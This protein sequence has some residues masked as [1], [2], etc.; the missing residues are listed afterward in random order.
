[1]AVTVCRALAID[2]WFWA[3]VD[4]LLIFCCLSG[5]LLTST[6]VHKD[7]FLYFLSIHNLATRFRSRLVRWVKSPIFLDFPFA[8][9]CVKSHVASKC[10]FDFGNALRLE[11]MINFKSFPCRYEVQIFGECHKFWKNLLTTYFKTEWDFFFF[12]LICV[13]FS[14]YGQRTYTNVSLCISCRA[15]RIVHF[16]IAW[17]IVIDPMKQSLH[18]DFRS[19]SADFR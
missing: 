2:G 17:Q 13:T 1:M 16:P 3:L 15:S 8:K 10:D 14:E 18:H 11:D 5:R 12:F 4:W 19:K 7:T 9:V 6:A